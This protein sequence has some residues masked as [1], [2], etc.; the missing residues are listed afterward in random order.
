VYYG[1]G[2]FLSLAVGRSVAAGLPPGSERD[3]IAGV[4]A[5]VA[6]GDRDPLRALE[7]LESADPGAQAA[8]DLLRNHDPARFDDLYAALPAETRATIERLS[9]ITQVQRLDMPVVLASAPRDAYFPAAESRAVVLAA[10]HAHLT[11]TD[12]FTHVIPHPSLGDPGDL[13]AFD[14]WAVRAL[15][16]AHR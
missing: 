11:V 2:P 15:Q 12:A 3:R 1:P 5:G 6:N 4:L 7:Q 8:L 13:F 14:A 16:A 10:P 9:P